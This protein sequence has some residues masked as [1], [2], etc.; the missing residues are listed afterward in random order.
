MAGLKILFVS[1]E[2]YPLAKTG[3]LADVAGTL[4]KALAEDNNDV[5]IVMPR[6]KRITKWDKVETDFGVPMHKYMETAIVKTTKLPPENKVPVYMIDSYKYFDRGDLYGYADDAERFIFF[7]RAV[8]EMLKAINWKPDVI[9]CNDWQTALIPTYL[10]T[11]YK[12]DPF[13]K[14]IGLVFTIHNMQYQGVTG[15]DDFR[16]TD[17]PQEL[18]HHERLEFYGALNLMKGGIIYADVV[19]TVSEEYAKEIQTPEYGYKLDG[20]LRAFSYKLTGVIN[21]LDYSIWDPAKD[22][23]IYKNYDKNSLDKKSE[24]KSSLQKELNLPIEKEVPLLGTVGRLSDQKGFDL[25]TP[26]IGKMLDEN[27][28]FVLLGTGEEKFHIMLREF[29]EKHSNAAILLKYD[30]KLAHKIYAASDMFLMPSRFEP[31]G[32][33]QMIALKYG[34]VPIVRHTGGL[35][36]TI[37]D[38]TKDK[39]KGNGFS[40]VE[41][42]EDALEDAIRRALKVY[43]EDKEAWKKLQIRGM[44]QSFSWHESAKKYENLYRKACL[45]AQKVQ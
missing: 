14:G 43:N 42:T 18:M 8:V 37:V 6:Y 9:H 5:R 39:V 23:I 15:A 11:I 25:L 26:V 44:S 20:L 12:H 28:Q 33:G 16:F 2:V 13:F 4:P 17:L 29:K 1:S 32:L 3:G 41:Y 27:I 19:N 35:A 7:S 24:N 21:G 22:Q 36:D 30:E 45:E 38:Y 40:F 10:R 31:C 34:S